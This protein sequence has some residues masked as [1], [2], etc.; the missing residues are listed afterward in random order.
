[1][2]LWALVVVL[3]HSPELELVQLM[4]VQLV[5]VQLVKW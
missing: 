5:L 3:E 1:M 4:V 2:Q